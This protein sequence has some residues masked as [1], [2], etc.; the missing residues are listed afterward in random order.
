MRK[1]LIPSIWLFLLI[2][3]C[4]VSLHAQSRRKKKS[5]SPVNF[6]IQQVG[7]GVWAAI[8]NDQYGRAICNAGI[9]DLGD[10]TLVFDAFMNPAAARELKDVAEELTGKFVCIVVNSHYHNDHIRGNQ[11]F[12]GE[13]TI[14]SSQFT[15]KEIERVEP[16]EQQ[17]EQKH[18]SGLLQA[19]K[20]RI[21]SANSLEKEELPLWIG[22]Y[23]GMIESADE[24]RMTLPNIVFNDS[25][26]IMGTSRNVKLV[27]CRNGHTA[28]DLVML[29]PDAGIA[30]MGDLLF[31]GRHPWMSDGNPIGWQASLKK[32]YEDPQ[33]T[34]FVPGHG[35]VSDKSA[36][37]T[38]Y[39]YFDTVDGMVKAAVSDSLQIEL[40][41]R[42]IPT[43]YETWYFSRFYQ[44]NLQF[45]IDNR[46]RL[47]KN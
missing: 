38:L 24:L 26:W 21:S 11:V 46:Q 8:S 44:P 9:V 12:A 47:F 36:L 40:M 18:A 35:P 41:E 34:T 37:K 10:K 7:T 42:P 20:K 13:A 4:H 15:R 29:I 16:Q 14:I 31:C 27:E 17:W 28:S 23:E 43:P 45:L 25:L 30:F 32:F 39:D 2:I 22:Y 33:Y 3:D 6:T 1:F 5:V 19:L